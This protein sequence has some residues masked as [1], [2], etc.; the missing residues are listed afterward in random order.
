LGRFSATRQSV[1]GVGALALAVIMS[2]FFEFNVTTTETVQAAVAWRHG[3][4]TVTITHGHGVLTVTGMPAAPAGDDYAV[5]VQHG[6][7]TPAPTSATFNVDAAGGATVDIPGD[8][9]DVTR[10]MVSPEPSSGSEVLN[11]TP[12]LVA[13]LD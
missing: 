9:T 12:V 6:T 10:V 1:V 8:L 3:G 4:A 11:T 7:D 2:L 13:T 5:W